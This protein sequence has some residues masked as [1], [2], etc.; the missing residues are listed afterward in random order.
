MSGRPGPRPV[1]P[2]LGT[3]PESE[4][5]GRRETQVSSPVGPLDTGQDDGHHSGRWFPTWVYCGTYGS[6]GRE[7][8]TTW[9]LKGKRK[10][11]QTPYY[12]RK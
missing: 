9:T 8:T 1:G 11:K 10:S 3:D 2:E 7:Q 4:T 12:P 6:V 5:G